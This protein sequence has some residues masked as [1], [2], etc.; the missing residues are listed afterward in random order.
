MDNSDW[1]VRVISLFISYKLTPA[2]G[3][4]PNLDPAGRV[5]GQKLAVEYEVSSSRK[6]LASTT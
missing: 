5:Y 6:A 2:N 3:S 4:L 1:R